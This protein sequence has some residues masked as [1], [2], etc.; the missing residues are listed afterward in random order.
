MA[1]DGE[2]TLTAAGNAP[3]ARATPR[4][5]RRRAVLRRSSTGY[6]LIA[7]AILLIVLMMVYPVVQTFYFSFSRV[8][9]PALRTTFVG[10]DNFARILRDPETG[11]LF[12]RTLVWVLGGVAL[13]IFLGLGAA[14]VFNAKV[15]GTVWMRIL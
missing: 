13:R 5:R 3:V 1:W 15:R 11:P 14:L 4:G 7:P 9:L 8:Q 2:G 6:I 12:R 10:F